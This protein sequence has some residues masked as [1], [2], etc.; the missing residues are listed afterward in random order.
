MAAKVSQH[1][2]QDGLQADSWWQEPFLAHWGP[3]EP[4]PM[5]S[6]CALVPSISL[7][8]LIPGNSGQRH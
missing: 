6:G 5:S 2:V 7:L 1:A 3:P 4:N 8:G